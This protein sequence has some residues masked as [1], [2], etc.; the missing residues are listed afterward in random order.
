MYSFHKR[1]FGLEDNPT[2][3]LFE[4][5]IL[6]SPSSAFECG[7]K[8][9][10]SKIHAGRFRLGYEQRNNREAFEAILLFLHKIGRCE[11]VCLNREIFTTLIDQ[12]I[13]FS[14]VM[15][16]GIGIDSRKEGSDSKVKFYLMVRGYPEK[17]DQALSLHQP[18]N[19]IHQYPLGDVFGFG[20][21]LYFDG[22]TDIEIYPLLSPKEL[23]DPELIDK[24]KLREA[25]TDFAGEYH[26]LHISFDGRGGR[27]LHFHPRHPRRF[28]QLVSNRQLSILYS[29]VPILNYVFHKSGELAPLAVSLSL[30]EKEIRTGN[31]ENINLQYAL[32]YKHQSRD[33]S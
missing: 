24:L 14:R 30:L 20:I 29:N 33:I 6:E 9:T 19:D 2:L 16:M 32:T 5:L 21:N 31:I 11:N 12:D 15:K 17:V 10:P 22:R 18:V 26:S 8:I 27:I 28:V 7:P 1:V 25:V 13:D 4:K 3:S 23:Q